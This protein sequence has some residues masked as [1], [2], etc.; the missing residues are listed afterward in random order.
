MTEP[1]NQTDLIYSR[2]LERQLEEGMALAQA[3]D[4][5]HLQVPPFAP[6]HFFA[7]YRCKGLAR[8]AAGEIKEADVFHVGI[9][10][11]PDYLRQVNPFDVV[12]LFTPG[13]WHPNVSQ[14]R[15]FICI[16]RLT[17]GT[18]LVD[19]LYQIF[20]ILTYQKYNPRE[21][22]SLNK[23]AC[24]WARQNQHLFPI[25]RRPLKRRVLCLEAR[26]A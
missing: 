26:P 6:P 1:M 24:A 8:D 21:D 2:F 11:P 4:I 7:E 3:S 19:I 13:V 10:F 22:D 16:G 14:D 9:Y 17:P 15:P 25:D 23:A 5:L 12:R 18:S 20:D